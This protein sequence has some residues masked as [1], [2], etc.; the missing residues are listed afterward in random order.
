M[1]LAVKA[2]T[3]AL[4]WGGIGLGLFRTFGG[5]RRMVLTGSLA[6]F[7]G[8]AALVGALAATVPAAALAATL[9]GGLSVG[10]LLFGGV[11]VTVL[12]R[13]AGASLNISLPVAVRQDGWPVVLS[14]TAAGA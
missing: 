9:R 1:A 8:G 7:A 4:C 2:M 14:S 5:A 6:V 12:Y 11:A 3:L 13:T 10:F